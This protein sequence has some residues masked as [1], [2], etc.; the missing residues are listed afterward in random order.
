MKK[1]QK[2]FPLDLCLL[3]LN[4]VFNNGGIR[5][6]VHSSSCRTFRST[7]KRSEKKR[8]VRVHVCVFILYHIPARAEHSFSTKT[9]FWTKNRA[10]DT[11]Q[12]MHMH[13]HTHCVLY[14]I[15]GKR[16]SYVVPEVLEL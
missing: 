10:S 9:L 6:S 2:D 16:Y 15:R 1:G 4:R 7:R 5:F 8:A 14:R 12:C 11:I 13:T 3:F